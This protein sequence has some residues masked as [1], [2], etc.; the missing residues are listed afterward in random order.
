MNESEIKKNFSKRVNKLRKKHNI[1]QRE[2]AKKLDI[3]SS[4]VGTYEQEK[5]LPRVSK[6]S[7]L[8]T[9][10]NVSVDYLLGHTDIP[11]PVNSIIK[12]ISKNNKLYML[13]QRIIAKDKYK[14]LLLTLAEIDEKHIPQIT[15]I[16]KTFKTNDKHQP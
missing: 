7:K 15:E 12:A 13:W 5:Q 10:F 2:L 16:L 3:T 8:A 9:L 11:E 1:T 14:E 4:A 6:V